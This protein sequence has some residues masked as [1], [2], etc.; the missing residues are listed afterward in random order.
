MF[1]KSEPFE[2]NGKTVTLYELS[3]LQRI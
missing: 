1:L 3:A 2:R